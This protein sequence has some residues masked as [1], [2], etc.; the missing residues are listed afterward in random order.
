MKDSYTC[1][2]SGYPSDPDDDEIDAQN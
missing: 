2:G 1:F